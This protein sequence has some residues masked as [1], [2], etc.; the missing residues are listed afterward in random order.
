MPSIDRKVLALTFAA[1]AIA[2][3]VF[4][5]LVAL[6]WSVVGDLPFVDLESENPGRQSTMASPRPQPGA[7]R[8]TVLPPAPE[9]L[10]GLSI[11][12]IVGPE[13]LLPPDTD[14]F[15][16]GSPV[17]TLAP[18]A[19]GRLL[20]ADLEGRVGVRNVDGDIDR[21][22][23]DLDAVTGGEW[24]LLSMTPAHN[25][26]DLIYAFLI[27]DAGSL[28]GQPQLVS[29]DGGGGAGANVTVVTDEF[30]LIGLNNLFHIGGGLVDAADGFLYLALGDGGLAARAQDFGIL[31][32]KV[33]RLDHTGEAAAG[34]PF[35]GFAGADDRIFAVGIRNVFSMV[36]TADGRIYFGQNGPEVCD[37][38]DLVTPGVNYGWSDRIEPRT[39]YA[40]DTCQI[41]VPTRAGAQAL[42]A[43]VW[44]FHTAPT[45]DNDLRAVAPVG[46]AYIPADTF[47][48]LGEG[49]AVCEF[50]TQRLILLTLSEDGR[51]VVDERML[52]DDCLLAVA[53]ADGLLY[54]SGADGV[55]SLTPE[56]G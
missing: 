52:A 34:N 36:E 50:N 8:P 41:T 55:Y 26:G 35:E 53:F 31:Q 43:P 49:I 47:P 25:D 2:G 6:A 10:G 7:A 37:R 45:G 29:F 9:R 11:E 20:F 51:S 14:T 33:L 42:E 1:G 18:L 13:H 15:G 40:G 39:G 4:V 19:D 17:A 27:K 16:Q 54:Y 12:Q 5:A 38:L 3:L 48:G 30:P 23:V 46:M 22:F 44:D 21:D 28:L 24:G 56:G 32:G